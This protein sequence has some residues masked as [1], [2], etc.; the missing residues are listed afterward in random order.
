MVYVIILCLTIINNLIIIPPK[1]IVEIYTI[2]TDVY[3][4]FNNIL[5]KSSNVILNYITVKKIFVIIVNEFSENPYYNENDEWDIIK[6]SEINDKIIK[7]LLDYLK[8]DITE[9]FFISFES[10]LKLG[11]KVPETLIKSIIS[12]LEHKDESKK[13]LFEFILHFTQDSTVEYHLLPQLYSPDFITRARAIMK[14]EANNDLKYIKF[15]MPLLDDP[16]DSVRYKAIKFLSQFSENPSI[17]KQLK[18]HLD[19]ELN[20]II[21]DILKGSLN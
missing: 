10:V 6:I 15:L 9:Q 5:F 17:Q 4:S 8:S 7:R 13:E 2:N 11:N 16:D 18:A 1:I 21:Y 20:P 3:F 12:E 19:K 14:I